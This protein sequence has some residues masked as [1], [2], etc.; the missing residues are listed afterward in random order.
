MLIFVTLSS[1]VKVFCFVFA[2]SMPKKG[3]R[4][5][6]GFVLVSMPKKRAG[7]WSRALFCSAV[8]MP[9]KGQVFGTGFCFVLLFQC[10]KNRQGFGTGLFSFAAK[11]GQAFEIGFSVLFGCL[12]P[13]KGQATRTGLCFSVLMPK[14]RAGVWKWAM[15]FLLCC[16]V[17]LF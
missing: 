1:G 11:K 3:R 4:L 13:K 15:L 17:L 10:Q 16:F 14:K 12:M 9:K 8:S 2:V 7:V 6:L 5:E